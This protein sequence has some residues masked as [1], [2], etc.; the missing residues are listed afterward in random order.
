MVPEKF[1]KK[2][3]EKKKKKGTY[4]IREEEEVM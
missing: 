2:G 3:D 4:E 1:R